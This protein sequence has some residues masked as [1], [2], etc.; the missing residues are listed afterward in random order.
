MRDLICGVNYNTVCHPQSCNMGHKVH[1]IY[2]RMVHLIL[3]PRMAI[4]R[5]GAWSAKNR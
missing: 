1:L 5:T 3:R 4:H 2:E